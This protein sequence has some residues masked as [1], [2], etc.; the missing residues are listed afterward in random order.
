MAGLLSLAKTIDRLNENIGRTV[1]W[2]ALFMVLVQFSVVL[3]RYVYG[4]GSI[5]MQE[6]IIYM[7]GFLFM[8]GAGYTLLHGG[9]V[10]VD[11]FY[12][13]ASERKQ[14]FVDFFGVIFLLFPVLILI[15]TYS[16]PYVADS[17]SIFE[18]SK[19]TSGIPAV[20]ILKSAIIAFCVLMGLQGISMAIHSLAIIK[21]IEHKAE[22]DGPGVI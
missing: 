4:I 1:S 12:G 11:I 19:E 14:A 8:L 16:L 7:H 10:R 9:H 5:F 18:S 21:G 3:L 20:Y 2:L 17:W 15:L 6:S 13:A 22:E